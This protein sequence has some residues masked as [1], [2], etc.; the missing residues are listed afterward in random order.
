M[1]VVQPRVQSRLYRLAEQLVALERDGW[2]LQAPMKGD[3]V[4]IVRQK[5]PSVD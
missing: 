4:A 5:A 2:Q 1:G 3:D